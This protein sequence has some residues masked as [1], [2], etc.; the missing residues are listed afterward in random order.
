MFTAL[1]VPADI[2]DP[3][4]LV[5]IEDFLTIQHH[6]E[7]TFDV[8]RGE[9]VSTDEPVE[10]SIFV[11]DEGLLTQMDDNPRASYF[12]S[13]RLVG[14]ALFAGGVDA[15]GNTLSVPDQ[16]PAMFRKIGAMADE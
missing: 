4:T 13:R 1:L 15:E 5:T 16:L 7:G 12:G 2:S 11:N 6:V 3:A 10:F 9:M 8:V 14:P